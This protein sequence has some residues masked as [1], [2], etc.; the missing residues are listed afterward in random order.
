MRNTRSR[1]DSRLFWRIS[2]LLGMKG[3]LAYPAMIADLPTRLPCWYRTPRRTTAPSRLARTALHSTSHPYR[4][5]PSPTP[6]HRPRSPRSPPVRSSA[7][8]CNRACRS[9]MLQQHHHRGPSPDAACRKP[10]P[11]APCR[12][13]IPRRI[14]RGP[15]PR[16]PRRSRPCSWCSRRYAR[17][18]RW[19]GERGWTPSSSR[20]DESSAVMVPGTSFSPSPCMP[21]PRPVRSRMAC[22][23]PRP[24]RRTRC[25]LR[26]ARLAR[27]PVFRPAWWEP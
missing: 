27:N 25:A 12:H 16:G 1:R 18:S 15:S 7:P 24:P 19:A 5:A 23:V 6:P 4:W 3:I 26:T 22:T 17:R 13:S 20:R 11:D 9:T 21:R 8:P 10:S 14:R 2:L